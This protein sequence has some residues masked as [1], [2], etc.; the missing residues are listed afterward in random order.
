MG[1]INLGHNYK[2]QIEQNRKRDEVLE[3]NKERFQY[4]TN[5]YWTMDMVGT[6]L[7][8]RWDDIYFPVSNFDFD[9]NQAIVEHKYP[10]RDAA[11]LEA[12][13]REPLI[14]KAT[15]IFVNTIVPGPSD[16][17]TQGDLFPTVYNKLLLSSFSGDTK[18]LQH[19]TIGEIQC[20]IRSFSPLIDA[21]FRGGCIAHIVWEETIT[22]DLD[23]TIKSL[24]TYVASAKQNAAALD[25][26][27]PA[28]NPSPTD[29]G[30]P[31]Y[32]DSLL[33]L[34][35]KIEAM[36]NAPGKF[37]GQIAGTID[38]LEGRCHMIINRIKS[39]YTTAWGQANQL[40]YKLKADAQTFRDTAKL[41]RGTIYKNR[42]VAYYITE[43]KTVFT[44]LAARLHNTYQELIDLNPMLAKMASIPAGTTVG[45]YK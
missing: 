9:V 13:G 7:P 44:N 11:R 17:W 34:V 24:Q 16:M 33:D 37:A 15:A 6:L 28:L 35:N 31:E 25:S 29:L 22:D 21:K 1:L 19:P 26:Q 23:A 36:I 32:K 42:T 2:E 14:M 40:A 4:P 27:M 45:Y 10:N 12:M 41:M 18:V 8:I 5:P 43:K 38:S 30:I 20:K 39:T 3:K